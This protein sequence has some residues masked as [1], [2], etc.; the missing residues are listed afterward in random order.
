MCVFVCMCWEGV[1]LSSGGSKG[2]Q[3]NFIQLGINLDRVGQ[4][5]SFLVL[6]LAEEV[7]SSRC[8]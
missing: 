2:S 8:P 5:S 4:G 3:G 1:F 7:I 6:L